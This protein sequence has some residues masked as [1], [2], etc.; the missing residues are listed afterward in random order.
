ASDLYKGKGLSLSQLNLTQSPKIRLRIGV[1]PE[2]VHQGG[3]NLFGRSFGDH[4]QEIL[5]KL[6]FTSDEEDQNH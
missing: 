1:N 5:M 2:S 6:S 3:V 4:P